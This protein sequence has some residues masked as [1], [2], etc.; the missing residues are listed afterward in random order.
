MPS[1]EYLSIQAMNQSSLKWI[2]EGVDVFKDKLDYPSEPSDEQLLGTAVHLLLL[3][4]H[5]KHKIVKKPKYDGNTR[6]GK[7]FKKLMEGKSFNHF[8]VTNGKKKTQNEM[9]YEIDHEEQAWLLG[10]VE[11][12]A[13]LFARDKETIVLSEDAYETA[14]KMAESALNNTRTRE[15]LAAATAKEKVYRFEFDDIDFKAQLDLEGIHYLEID[16]NGVYIP[17]HFVLDFK[18]TSAKCTRRSIEEEIRKYWYHFQGA[19]YIIAY[20]LERFKDLD[21]TNGFSKLAEIDFIMIFIKSTRP[22]TVYP[23]KLSL[24]LLAEGYGAYIS[25]CKKYNYCL[26]HNPEFKADNDLVEI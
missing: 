9:F 3:E 1:Q 7:I 19:A 23:V 20:L 11:E 16:D 18:S 8:P 22:Y 2:L 25:A 24:N 12:H 4:P 13:G 10:V 26:K 21:L 5:L 14:H 6:Q 17:R 15:L